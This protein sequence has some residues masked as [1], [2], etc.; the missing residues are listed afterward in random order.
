MPRIFQA[1]I[2]FEDVIYTLKKPNRHED[3]IKHMADD[4]GM[5][6]PITGEQGFLDSNG[7]FINREDALVLARSTGQLLKEY[8]PKYLFSEDVW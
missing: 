7:N 6:T 2:K 1:A 4:L 3:I 8:H 5:K